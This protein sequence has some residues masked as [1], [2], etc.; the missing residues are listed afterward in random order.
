VT[1]SSDFVG[2]VSDGSFGTAAMELN[3][4]GLTA[5]KSWFYF[6]DRIVCLGAGITSDKS[7]LDIT[8]GV[9]QCLARGA[10]TLETGTGPAEPQA[11]LQEYAAL[12]WAWHDNVGYLFPEPQKI[13]LG[14]QEQTGKWSEVSAAA[15]PAL[16][17][18]KVFSIWIDHGAKPREAHYSYQILPGASPAML[19]AQTGAPDV[20]ILNNTS[21]LQAVRHAKLKVTEAVFYQP[22][23]LAY[24]HGKTITVDHPCVLLFDENK[25]RITIA[26]PT[27]KLTGITVTRNGEA[28][29]YTLPAG[30][31][32]GSSFTTKQ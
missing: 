9:N 15:N 5:K 8:T 30:A 26:D 25:N 32:A 12:Q 28:V 1:N 16:V 22:G 21:A 7:D 20:A 14:S 19:R 17:T 6:D 4:G 3:R 13:T 27:Q 10:I 2:G 24:N 23:T 29:K 11:G 18:E 31:Q